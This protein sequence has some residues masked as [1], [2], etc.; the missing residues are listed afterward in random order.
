MVNFWKWYYE[1]DIYIRGFKMF[2]KIGVLVWLYFMVSA[3][4]SNYF[5]F[6]KTYDTF[7]Q[8]VTYTDVRGNIKHF[9]NTFFIGVP[10]GI[11]KGTFIY[12]Y[13]TEPVFKRDNDAAL[14]S[15]KEIEKHSTTALTI[16]ILMFLQDL[17]IY[18]Y[19]KAKTLGIPYKQTLWEGIV[20]S[21]Y[22]DLFVGAFLYWKDKLTAPRVPK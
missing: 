12:R 16:F 10:L 19:A 2:L 18:Y 15:Y 9:N 21:L 22:L 5:Y 14:K 6:Y 8:E 3:P 13:L 4:V 1:K 11:N 7:P 17:F 20:K